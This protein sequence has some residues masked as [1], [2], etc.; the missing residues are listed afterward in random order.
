MVFSQGLI[1]NPP[2]ILREGY[3]PKSE[4]SDMTFFAEAI[5][6]Y[7]ENTKLFQLSDLLMS[8]SRLL[9][10]SWAYKKYLQILLT[11]KM[12]PIYVIHISKSFR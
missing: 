9:F 6:G 2:R 11:E 1:P 5:I 12:K 3:I 10:I 4:N 7:Q 8:I